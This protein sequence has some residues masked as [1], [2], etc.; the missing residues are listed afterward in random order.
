MVV[1]APFCPWLISLSAGS[2]QNSSLVDHEEMPQRLRDDV[3]HAFFAGIGVLIEDGKDLNVHGQTGDDL[4][5]K[6][7]I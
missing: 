3:P 2:L 6:K 4:A 7:N 1:K 5:P